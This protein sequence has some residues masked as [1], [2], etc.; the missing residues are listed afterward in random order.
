MKKTHWTAI[1]AALCLTFM[2]VLITACQGSSTP[3]SGVP[4][5]DPADEPG[6]VEI[7]NDDTNPVIE[8]V[9]LGCH[10]VNIAVRERA[11]TGANSVTH[12]S[13]DFIM[14]L[15]TDR[16]TYRAADVIRIWGT[17]EYVGDQDAIEIWHACPFM[18]FSISGGGE[19]DVGWN[20][21][22]FV[23]DILASSVLER[24]RVYHFEYQKS[25]GFDPSG[26]MAEFWE[27][28]FKEEDLRLPPGE[29]T[30]TLIG[31]FSLSDR[32][33]GYESGL[34]AELAITVTR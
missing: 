30:V 19:I 6:I 13:G 12:A 28:F 31:G 32:I 33:A 23:S 15:N 26:P 5:P 25:G 9:D 27:N 7:E 4:T 11:L 18:I 34:R 22:G 20:L 14:T 16:R 3:G 1:C 2:L 17:L 24:G 8:I 29:Y 10:V 21:G